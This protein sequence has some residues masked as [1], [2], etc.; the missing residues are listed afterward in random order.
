MSRKKG[1][2][3]TGGSLSEYGPVFSIPLPPKATAHD[4]AMALADPADASA[5]VEVAELLKF[6]K[7]CQLVKHTGA[8]YQAIKL[9]PL[10]LYALPGNGCPEYPQGCDE[11]P[12]PE[13]PMLMYALQHG[14]EDY[15]QRVLGKLSLELA[16][17]LTKFAADQ[18]V[19]TCENGSVVA[20]IRIAT[21]K[22]RVDIEAPVYGPRLVAY[23]LLGFVC[24]AEA[25][26]VGILAGT[27][28]ICPLQL[29]VKRTAYMLELFA[30]STG[31]RGEE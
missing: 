21:P 17:T 6:H 13:I 9:Y 24:A 20:P 16:P 18:L 7:Q 22:Y 30:W 23:L 4:R 12:A 29:Y 10:P 26:W 15:L 5:A 27:P 31:V 11:I 19:Y 1:L 2:F 25:A 8:T 28:Q 14:P 3:H